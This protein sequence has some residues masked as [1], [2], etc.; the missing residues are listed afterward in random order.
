MS[1]SGPIV[2]VE[3]DMDDQNIIG[4][5]FTELQIKNEIKYFSTGPD[6]F[7]Y[8]KETTDQPFVIFSDINLP[9]QN[10]IEFKRDIDGDPELRRKSIPFIFYSTYVD[11]KTVD[12]AYIEL[13][14]QGFFQK[15]N[16]FGEIKKAI[17]LIV[18]YWKTCK[19]P[20]SV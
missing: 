18:E 9:I 7:Q 4:E 1:K 2:V 20:N 17:M 6:A 16:S 11:Q 12:Q 3:D 8:L 14:V 19:H 15:N 5:V 13:N 10:G